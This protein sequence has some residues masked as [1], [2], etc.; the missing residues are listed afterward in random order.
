[1]PALETIQQYAEA[2]S[3]YFVG[4][5]GAAALYLIKQNR[6]LRRDLQK[7]QSLEAKTGLLN[8]P[9]FREEVTKR[10]K[11]N[12]RSSDHDRVH[13]LIFGDLDD[14]KR[15]ND[16]LTHPVVD[17]VALL[18]IAEIFSK[19]MRS[20]S[21]LACR[22]G[23]E[24]IVAFLGDTD[25]DG[26]TFVCGKIQ[27]DINSLEIGDDMSPLGITLAC[28]ELPQGGDLESTLQAL[29][30]AVSDAKKIPGKNQIVSIGA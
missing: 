14:F 7:A 6:V 26:A 8:L 20:D 25:V 19:S 29:S 18:P 4:G 3:P 28:A 21:D 5:L 12:R 10:T 11:P 13:A 22:Y 2:A 24:E 9:A 23:G 17:K 15:L 1:M 27:R 30:S 16:R